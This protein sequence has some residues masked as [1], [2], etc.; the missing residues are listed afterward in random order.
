M[1][2]ENNGPFPF[3]IV[4]KAKSEHG[5]VH[6]L[7][8]EG[9]EAV[10]CRRPTRGEYRKFKADR[11]DDAKRIM[12]VE[13]LFLSCLVHPPPAEFD[14]VLDRRPAL[15]DVFGVK[16]LELAGFDEKVESGKL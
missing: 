15:A 16:L 3:Q 5:E 2:I 6:V 9:G 7:T 4:E 13:S 10:I 14:A 1:K 8:A 11:A 12:A